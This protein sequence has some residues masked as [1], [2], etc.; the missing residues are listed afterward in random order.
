M[1]TCR[2]SVARCGRHAPVRAGSASKIAALAVAVLLG[3]C[4]LA[5]PDSTA[6][7]LAAAVDGA[8]YNP[9]LAARRPRRA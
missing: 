1:S 9:C 7:A 5:A 6:P 2:C 4:G 8:A 3:G